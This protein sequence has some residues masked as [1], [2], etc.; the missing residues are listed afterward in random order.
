MELQHLQRQWRLSRPI[1]IELESQH[2]VDGQREL[3][4]L[5]MDTI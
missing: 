3:I 5:V 2:L 4:K 1:A